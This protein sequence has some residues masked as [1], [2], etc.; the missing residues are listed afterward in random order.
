MRCTTEVWYDAGMFDVFSIGIIFNAF[1]TATVSISALVLM[2][3]L[4]VKRRTLNKAMQAYAWFWWFTALVWFPSIFRY[5][6]I[7]LGVVDTWIVQLD[8]L[9]QTAVFFSGPPL[10]YYLVGRLTGNQKLALSSSL[11]SFALA[12]VSLWFLLQPDGIAIVNVSTFAA[13]QKVNNTSLIIFS[14]QIAVIVAMLT[15]D[16]WR[17]YKRYRLTRDTKIFLEGAYSFPIFVYVLLGAIDESKIITDW[18]LVVFR[19]LYAASMLVVFVL[20]L[21]EAGREE[22]NL[23]EKVQK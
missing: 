23:Y 19:M 12:F 18:P 3:A 17:Y 22:N 16:M 7:G 20:L 6:A 10:F 2:T 21:Q 4:L 15:Y 9:V 14:S 1:V 5:T 8:I 11:T 13:E